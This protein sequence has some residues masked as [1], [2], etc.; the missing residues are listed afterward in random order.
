MQ[1]SEI[2]QRIRIQK[3]FLKT[4]IVNFSKKLTLFHH[5]LIPQ[6]K[7]SILQMC[8]SC[9]IWGILSHI[10]GILYYN[11][12]IN[13]WW[14]RV[15]FFKN[16]FQWEF[17]KNLL[18]SSYLNDFWILGIGIIVKIPPKNFCV[19]HICGILCHEREFPWN[20]YTDKGLHI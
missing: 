2:I 20:P 12:G 19:Y 4:S 8:D 3:I 1:N 9:H 15:N 11:C 14:N 18:D 5:C 10:C 13:Q 6:L 7:Y 16:I 17:K